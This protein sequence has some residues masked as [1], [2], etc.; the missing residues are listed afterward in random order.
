[1]SSLNEG[2]R[3]IKWDARRGEPFHALCLQ[4]DVQMLSAQAETKWSLGKE[5]LVN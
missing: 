1:M 4:F 5:R 3:G 2:E